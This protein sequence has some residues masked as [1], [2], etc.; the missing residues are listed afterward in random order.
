M[1]R[2]PKPIRVGDSTLYKSGT[3]RFDLAD[4]YHLAVTASWPAFFTAFVASFVLINLL[5]AFAYVLDPQ[6]IANARPHVLADAFFF[7]METLATVGYGTMAPSSLW[8]H[9]VSG[10]E[11]IT[12]IAFTAIVTGIIF[13]RFSKVKSK[14]LFADKVVVCQHEGK[15]TLM[16]RLAYGRDTMLASVNARLTVLKASKTAEGR[17]FR[18]AHDAQL[19]RSHMPML[20]L[21]WTVM[22]EIDAGSPLHGMTE[23]QVR[24]G[25]LRL[26][27]TI[28]ARDHALSSPIFDVRSYAS[29]DILFG[30]VYQDLV[31]FDSEMGTYAD[32]RD[33]S[34]VH[35][36]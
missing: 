15:P 20:A 8:G 35:A 28:D 12:G 6:S 5:F 34:L 3:T 10:V 9:V 31:T 25:G 13:V 1:K 16:I 11:I 29:D 2:K 19:I 24:E 27:V 18:N 30:T 26:I 4:P 21:T 36:E 7:S 14:L 32:V 23:Q 33:I 22:H 17:A